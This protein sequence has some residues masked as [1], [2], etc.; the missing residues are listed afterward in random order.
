MQNFFKYN[1]EINNY[2]GLFDSVIKKYQIN[3]IDKGLNNLDAKEFDNLLTSFVVCFCTEVKNAFFEQLCECKNIKIVAEVFKTPIMELSDLQIDKLYKV[4]GKEIQ[5][6]LF[7][8]K[9]QKKEPTANIGL[10]DE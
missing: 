2:I 7:T 10:N 6:E 8:Y 4:Y 3:L 1:P 5:K 9:K